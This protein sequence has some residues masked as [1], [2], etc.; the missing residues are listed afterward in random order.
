MAGNGLNPAY[1]I[2]SKATLAALN[3]SYDI[4]AP[5]LGQLKKVKVSTTTAG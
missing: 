2:A 1:L 3:I 4:P 5:G